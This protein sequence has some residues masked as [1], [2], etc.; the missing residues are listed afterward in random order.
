MDWWWFSH[1]NI[2]KSVLFSQFYCTDKK[3]PTHTVDI[4]FSAHGIKFIGYTQYRNIGKPNNLKS[5]WEQY[6]KEHTQD[7]KYH[8]KSPMSEG[9]EP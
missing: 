9:G 3:K 1:R 8:L 7:N 5:V 2:I 6:T 4:K